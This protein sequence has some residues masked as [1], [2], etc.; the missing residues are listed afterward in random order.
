LFA[1]FYQ[2]LTFFKPNDIVQKGQQIYKWMLKLIVT[3]VFLLRVSVETNTVMA[4]YNWNAA[5]FSSCTF[6]S[7]RQ[8]RISPNFFRGSG[9]NT[10]S[11]QPAIKNT[12]PKAFLCGRLFV[13]SALGS[14]RM[15]FAFYVHCTTWPS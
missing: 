15:Q 9:E 4:L 7:K 1:V 12:A 11:I 8:K 3:G 14:F 5:E 2:E 6:F 10:C 13:S